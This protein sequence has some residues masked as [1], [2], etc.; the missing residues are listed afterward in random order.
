MDTKTTLEEMD[1]KAQQEI[2]IPQ[3]QAEPQKKEE[4]LFPALFI[5]E[6]LK[7]VV[8][9]DETLKGYMKDLKETDSSLSQ[10]MEKTEELRADYTSLYGD[11][12]KQITSM[13]EWEAAFNKALETNSQRV[14]TKLS[15]VH[16]C[17]QDREER[18]IR[19][20]EMTEQAAS[21]VTKEL[22]KM[23][24]FL[25]QLEKRQKKLLRVVLI[26]ASLLALLMV[27]DIVLR[28]IFR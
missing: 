11:M 16:S 24:R 3:H 1:R 25:T 26:P 14:V 17:L 6:D 8:G 10:T 21:S 23:G 27:A 12:K 2:K 5:T 19:Q 13:Q 15:Q 4:R 22:I 20:T 7:A 28:L 9:M 18:I